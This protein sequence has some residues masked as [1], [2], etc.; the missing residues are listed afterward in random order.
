MLNCG[1]FSGDITQKGYEKK[2]TKLLTP[3]AKSSSSKSSNDVVK[4]ASA[5]KDNKAQSSDNSKTPKSSQ[6]DQNTK[7]GRSRYKHRR[8]YNE[9]RYHSEVRQEA[10]QQGGRL[11][12]VF[13]SNYF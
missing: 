12:Y 4:E 9:K 5:S 6:N 2:R 11:C 7:N 3:F 1:F 13:F 8:Y 10:V